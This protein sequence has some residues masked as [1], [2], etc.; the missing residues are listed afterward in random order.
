MSRV[1][2]G[3][4]P[5][6]VEPQMER[7]RKDLVGEIPQLGRIQ[8]R[9]LFLVLSRDRPAAHHAAEVARGG[10]G[11]VHGDREG[12]DPLIPEEAVAPARIVLASFILSS[13]AAHP[14]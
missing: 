5:G 14:Q 8:R 4:F 12:V 10:S 9:G 6:G 7:R 1:G 2:R 3:G 11:Q 13:S